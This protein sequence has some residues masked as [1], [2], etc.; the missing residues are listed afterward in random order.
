MM[1]RAIRAT[2]GFLRSAAGSRSQLQPEMLVTREGGG[3]PITFDVPPGWEHQLVYQFPYAEGDKVQFEKVV[4][5][6]D[7]L[8]EATSDLSVALVYGLDAGSGE[9]NVFLL[10]TDPHQ[11]HDRLAPVVERSDAARAGF[12]AGWRD[13]DRTEYELLWP[14]GGPPFQVV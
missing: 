4:A 2:L 8:V 5:L 10:T 12:R 3:P 14:P 1:H 9:M 7:A 11:A 6:E 13:L